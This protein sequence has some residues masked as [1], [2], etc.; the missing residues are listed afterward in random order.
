[1][2]VL[3]LVIRYKLCVMSCVLLWYNLS[4]EYFNDTFFHFVL[5][6]FAIIALSLGIV[7]AANFFGGGV[8]ML[9]C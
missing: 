6:F 9:A 5:G 8:C 2:F 4:V 1:M 3:V 7:I